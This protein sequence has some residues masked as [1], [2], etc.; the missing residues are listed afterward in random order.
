[1]VLIRV[2]QVAKHA[3]YAAMIESKKFEAH[4]GWRRQTR[5]S[6]VGDNAVQGPSGM[7]RRGDHCHDAMSGGL[8][9]GGGREDQCRSMFVRRLIGEGKGYA[10]HVETIKDHDKRPRLQR[11][12]TRPT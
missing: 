8:I 12:P 5:C 6:K 7:L 11:T 1:M 3:E 4:N 9:E 10:H 2:G